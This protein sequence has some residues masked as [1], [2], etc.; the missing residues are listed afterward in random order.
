MS[1]RFYQYLI[2][3]AIGLALLIGF[4]SLIAHSTN[5]PSF[6]LPRPIEVWKAFLKELPLLLMATCNTGIHALI[7]FLGAAI[8]GFFTAWLFSISTRTYQAVY[9]WLLILQ[10]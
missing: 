5:V 3:T 8:F 2:S 1:K 4:W 9:P 7:G 10:L 6:I